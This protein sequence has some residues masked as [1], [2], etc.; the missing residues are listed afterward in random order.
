[1]TSRCTPPA[2]SRA[3]R[4]S[5]WPLRRRAATRRRGQPRH[6]ARLDL[7]KAHTM[8]TVLTAT[9]SPSC[10]GLRVPVEVTGTFK[11]KSIGHSGGD[12]ESDFSSTLSVN[13]IDGDADFCRDAGLSSPNPI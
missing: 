9:V 1:L 10:V 8:R 4:E 12:V 11:P 3:S 2:A 5:A 6:H 13:V 7:G